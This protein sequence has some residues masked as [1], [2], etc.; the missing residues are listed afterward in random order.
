MEYWFNSIV[1]N[2]HQILSFGKVGKLAGILQPICNGRLE[3]F[4][5][6]CFMWNRITEL[7]GNQLGFGCVINLAL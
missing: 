3:I 2:M 1:F 5:E 7:T 4:H 6:L